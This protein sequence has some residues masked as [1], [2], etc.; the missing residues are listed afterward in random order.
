MIYFASG[1]HF[2]YGN[3]IRL[4]G[5][6]FSDV[7]A[8]NTVLIENRNSRVMERDEIYIPGDFVFK[9]KGKEAND[10]SENSDYNCLSGKEKARL[11]GVIQAV[12]EAGC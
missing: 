7:N 9:G 4:C 12:G 1:P 3:I 2:W 5:R 8:M 6:P 11:Q 10:L